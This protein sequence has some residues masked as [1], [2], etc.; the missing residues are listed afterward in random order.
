MCY[1]IDMTSVPPESRSTGQPSSNY[2]HS[3]RS[4]TY[5]DFCNHLASFADDGYRDFIKKGIPT[6]RPIIGVRVPK[7]REIVKALPPESLEALIS[8]V[9]ISLEEVIARGFMI[10]RLDYER[11]LDLFNS[12]IAYITDWC[13]C[14]LFCSSLRP[15]IRRHLADFLDSKIDPLLVT[16]Q[17]F[18]TRVGLVLLFSYVTPDY[19]ALIYDRVTRLAAREEYY[20]KMAISW[21]LAECFI[22]FPDETLGYMLSSPLPKWTYNKTI[23]KICDSYRVPDEIKDFLRTKRR[24]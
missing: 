9:P 20:V 21:L 22:K 14:D 16:G 19:L 4:A 5:A 11:M 3:S 2:Y 10:G 1:Y 8:G 7:I 24:K 23:S 6:D 15:H 13:T 18:P 17:E 12:Q